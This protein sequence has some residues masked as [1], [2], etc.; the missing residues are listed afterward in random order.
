MSDADAL[1]DRDE[2]LLGVVE[3][4]MD[5]IAES[6][7]DPDAE[8]VELRELCRGLA[9]RVDTAE[10][11]IEK[12]RQQRQDIFRRLS[13]LENQ[14]KGD[15]TVAGSNELEQ[16][17]LAPESMKD[18]LTVNKRRALQLYENWSRIAWQTQAHEGNDAYYVDT[19]TRKNAK[20]HP[21]RLKHELE[22]L[23]GEPLQWNDVY[24]TMQQMALMSGGEEE[25]DEYGRTHIVGGGYEYHEKPTADNSKMKRVLVQVDR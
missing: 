18:Q 9:D 24:R 17:A 15:V 16:Y 13:Q 21:S 6:T 12:S 1:T 10:E 20:N 19:N 7:A 4:E 2:A 11:E 3:D 8:I 14:I 5:D 23:E 22:T 25:T